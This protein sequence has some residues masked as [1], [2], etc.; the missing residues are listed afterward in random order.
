MSKISKSFFIVLCS[1]L[2]ITS[3]ATKAQLTT[4]VL[5]TPDT[6]RERILSENISVLS[7][8]NKVITAKEEVNRAR[9]ALLPSLNLNFAAA[10]NPVSFLLSTVNALMPFLLPSNWFNLSESKRNFE[11]EAEA[12]NITQLNVLASAYSTAA[13][14]ATEQEMLLIYQKQ[15]QNQRQ[16]QKL[17][18]EQYQAGLVTKDEL[19]RTSSQLN[20]TSIQISRTRELIGKEVATLRQMLSLSLE[21]E[22]QLQGFEVPSSVAEGQDI[23]VLLEESLRVSPEMAQIRKLIEAG[24]K[25]VGKQSFSVFS[26]ASLVGASVG[27]QSAFSNI[28]GQAGL[29]FGGT[30][31]PSIKLAKL[32][33]EQLQL[34]QVEIRQSQTQALESSLSSVREATFQVDQAI[35]AERSLTQVSDSTLQKYKAGILDLQSVLLVQDSLTQAS[36]ARLNARVNLNNVR[37]SLHR[38]MHTDQFAQV[39]PCVITKE[40]FRKGASIDQLCHWK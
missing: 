24:K 4:A 38:L 37:V 28:T 34:R 25:R 33:V 13:T 14:V 16:L 6:L 21:T 39:Q 15:Q 23:G 7:S 32:N 20:L 30:T 35:Q 10:A 19:A 29:S 12:F 2:M 31:L 11:A 40:K 5:I 18:G 3:S 1:V 9:G 26:G 27:A 36:L 22:I 17:V 8:L